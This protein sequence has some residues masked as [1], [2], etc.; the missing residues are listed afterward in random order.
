MRDR[1]KLWG[2]ASRLFLNRV[3]NAISI[4]MKN[5]TSKRKARRALGCLVLSLSLGG[6][7]AWGQAQFKDPLDYAAVSAK[8]PATRPLMAVTV[9]GSRIVAV[10][11][12]GL[13]VISNDGG[14]SWIQARVPIQSDLLAVNFPVPSTGWAVGHDGV[15]LR[16]DDGGQTWVKQLDGRVAGSLFHKFYEARAASGDVAAKHAMGQI[17]QNFKAGATLPYLDVWFEDVNT[18]F[19]V[20]AF[21]MVVATTDGGKT[22]T[23]WLDK[24]DNPQSLN[25]NS[26]HGIGGEVFIAGERGRVYKLDR[27]SSRFLASSTGYAGSFFGIAG[28]SSEIL[29]FGLRG[30]AYRSGDHGQTWEA[31]SMPSTS[32]INAGVVRPGS[33]GFVLA[34]GAGQLLLS[35]ATARSFDTVLA[36]PQMR[37]TGIA[38]LADGSVIVTGLNG[39]AKLGPS[40]RSVHQ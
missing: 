5:L 19:A 16:S 25:L 21:G 27:G 23:P 31:L 9:A 37:L 15:I 26:V 38:A 14:K 3:G 39:V 34:N 13:I 40:G 17:E 32:T 35:D 36:Q 8:S 24:I 4:Q 22:W 30:V 20:G 2:R 29:A 11:S 10:G 33:G 7:S 18:G 6:P 12:R 28:D 1:Q